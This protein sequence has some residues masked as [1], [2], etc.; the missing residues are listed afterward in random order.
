MPVKKYYEITYEGE[1][2]MLVYATSA[3]QARKQAIDLL[4]NFHGGRNLARLKAREW[5]HEVA[6]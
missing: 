5:K 4:I 1:C 3:R 2:L 6:H